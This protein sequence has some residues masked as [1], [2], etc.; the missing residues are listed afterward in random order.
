M[1]P[2]NLLPWRERRRLYNNKQFVLLLCFSWVFTVL[3]A[4][5]IWGYL[6]HSK[7]NLILANQYIIDKNVRLEVFLKKDQQ[8]AQSREQILDQLQQLQ[9]LDHHRTSLIQLWSEMAEVIPSTMYLTHITR[10]Q[11]S[12]VVSGKANESNQVSQLVQQLQQ[13]KFL[14]QVQIRFINNN[15]SS[16]NTYFDFEIGAKMTTVASNPTDFNQAVST[17]ASEPQASETQDFSN[18]AGQ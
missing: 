1:R 7:Q 9:R 12:I 11:G 17:Q 14:Q 8:Q 5:A 15:P 3:G 10:E 6:Y 18:K 4:A 13:N 16:S 2:I